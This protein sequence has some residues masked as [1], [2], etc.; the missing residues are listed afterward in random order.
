MAEI[1][2]NC[3]CDNGKR[4]LEALTKLLNERNKWLGETAEQ[5]CTA[6]MLDV[7]VSLRVETWTATPRKYEAEINMDSTNFIPSCTMRKG[8][9]PIFCLRLGKARYTPK[10]HERI[11][12]ATQDLKNTQVWRWYDFKN[13]KDGRPKEWLIVAHSKAEA[14]KWAFE[15][16]KKRVQRYKGLAKNAMSVLMMKSGSKT[17][18]QF[19][20]AE[21]QS[22]ANEMTTVE[23]F[24]NGR[25]FKITVHDLLNYA[26]LAMNDAEN[27][28]NT[29]MM[30]AANKIASV[31]NTKC[32]RL[33]FFEKIP[34]PFPEVRKRR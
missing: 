34:T 12:R 2:V 23:R 10:P 17:A 25:E 5:A 27:S 9:K 3:T 8:S 28:I 29:A 14:V 11:R 19:D 33:L 20:N 24:G 32:K 26:K 21:A 6:T 31:I 7:L 1:S 30:K 18:S 4:P 15:R 13:G 22:K 16:I